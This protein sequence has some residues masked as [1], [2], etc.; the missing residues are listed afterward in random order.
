MYFEQVQRHGILQQR[1]GRFFMTAWKQAA[2]LWLNL[3]HNE[4][5]EATEG[6][7]KWPM[8]EPIVNY[9]TWYDPWQ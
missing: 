6:A 2:C 7:L 3:G 5:T 9:P 4:A 8:C 1:V